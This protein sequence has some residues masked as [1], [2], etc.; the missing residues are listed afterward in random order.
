MSDRLTGRGRGGCQT[1]LRRAALGNSY[2][3]R[4][5]S[6]G[7]DAHNDYG[8]SEQYNA[9]R[10]GKEVELSPMGKYFPFPLIA[11]YGLGG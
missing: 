9:M 4:F 10:E 11:T 8:K 1:A 6:S 7:M 3:G 5:G 2:Y